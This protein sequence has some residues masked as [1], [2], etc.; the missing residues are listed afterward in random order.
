[1][2]QYIKNRG[3]LEHNIDKAIQFIRRFT[4]FRKR[5]LVIVDKL[6]DAGITLDSD[7]DEIID[8]RED[9][10]AVYFNKQQQKL[11]MQREKNKERNQHKPIKRMHYTCYSNHDSH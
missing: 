2:T 5:D 9:F 7:C 4:K 6:Y 1:M 3:T 10:L 8:K 11:Y